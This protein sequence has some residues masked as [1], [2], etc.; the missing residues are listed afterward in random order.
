M[1][2]LKKVF[3]KANH[4]YSALTYTACAFASVPKQAELP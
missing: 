1:H 3:E 2:G 4:T